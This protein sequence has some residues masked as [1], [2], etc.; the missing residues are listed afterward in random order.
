MLLPRCGLFV[1]F[2]LSGMVQALPL[3]YVGSVLMIH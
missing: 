2:L 1:S 3:L